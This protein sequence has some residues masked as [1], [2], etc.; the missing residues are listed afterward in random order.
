MDVSTRGLRIVIEEVAL[1]GV[2]PDDPAVAAA[3]ELALAPAL[4]AH[5]LGEA[6]PSV[7][8]SVSDAIATEVSR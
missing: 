8:S 7:T 6:A 1:G 2:A 5:G 3:L 4:G